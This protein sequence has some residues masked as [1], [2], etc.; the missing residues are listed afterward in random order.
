MHGA[1]G[2]AMRLPDRGPGGVGHHHRAVEMV[3]MHPEQTGVRLIDA[4]VEHGDREI[5]EPDVFPD[6]RAGCADLC[7]DTVIG[8]VDIARRASV[9]D[10]LADRLREPR[11]AVV[12]K[13][14]QHQRT[15][16]HLADV[17]GGNI[18]SFADF[19][20]NNKSIGLYL[21][22]KYFLKKGNFLK[23]TA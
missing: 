17:P 2:L 13:I 20:N 19:L 10:V 11:L 6:R 16:L 4:R 5:I 9:G 18:F 1:E 3:G 7:D 12:E 22:S 23:H 8:I 15:E 21:S 14:R